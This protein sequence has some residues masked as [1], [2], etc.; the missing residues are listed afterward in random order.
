MFPESPK[1][2][3]LKPLRL[4]VANDLTPLPCEGMGESNS[5]LLQGE[6]L[7]EKSILNSPQ[8]HPTPT[9]T[10]FPQRPTIAEIPALT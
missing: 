1:P 9:K 3:L 10:A 5:P 4:L 7:G 6:G 2:K 8:N